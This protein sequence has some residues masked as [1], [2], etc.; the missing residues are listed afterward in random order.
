LDKVNI[1]E[2][3]AVAP[4]HIQQLAACAEL[5]DIQKEN[6]EETIRVPSHGAYQQKT[7]KVALKN[8]SLRKKVVLKRF[9]CTFIFVIFDAT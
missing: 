6:S 9:F 3:Y 8:I 2:L 4:M 1:A 7:S 5:R